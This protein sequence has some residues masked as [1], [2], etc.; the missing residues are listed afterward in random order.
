MKLLHWDKAFPMILA[1]SFE[2]VMASK[3]FTVLLKLNEYSYSPF[4]EECCRRRSASSNMM[5]PQ[6][7]SQYV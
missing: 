6:K 5:L 4:C 3:G 1:K 7:L 2:V